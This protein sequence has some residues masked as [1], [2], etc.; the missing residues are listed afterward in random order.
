MPSEPE[1]GRFS[2]TSVIP[3]SKLRFDRNWWPRDAID[4]GRV[5][6]FR[7]QM[8]EG[9]NFPPIE[10]VPSADGTYLIGDGVHRSVAAKSAGHTEIEVEI[11]H[12]QENETPTDCAYR[13]ALET[14][15]RSALPLT[16]S[17][18]RRAAVYL[19]ENRS[20]MSRRAIAHLVG[21]AHSSVNR[22]A[23]EVDQSSTPDDEEPRRTQIG[24][25]PDQ[26]ASR[27]VVALE[28][29][30]ESRG[31]LDYLAPR[32]MGRHLA[33][34]FVDRF[35]DE[36]LTEAKHFQTWINVAVSALEEGQG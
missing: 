25:N 13:I 36:C 35:G 14:A 4:Q 7:L 11:V 16:R 31:L 8:Q 32:R 29:L 23:I 17:E 21:V 9:G 34:A 10:V 22:W 6:M 12:P 1:S 26:V 19:L 15:S 5:E 18:R 3:I 33:S 24:P 28:R 30:S 27:L 20:D 2:Q